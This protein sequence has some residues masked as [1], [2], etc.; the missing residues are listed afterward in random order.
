MVC[1][2]NTDEVDAVKPTRKEADADLACSWWPDLKDIWT[3]LRWPECCFG[4][5][6]WHDGAV[7]SE[8]AGSKW[9]DDEGGQAGQYTF[10]FCPLG[11]KV[12]TPPTVR[13]SGAARQG[14]T[15]SYAP[16]LWTEWNLGHLYGVVVRAYTFAH[17]PG[18]GLP[19]T[20]REAPFAWVRFCIHYV[21]PVVP[22]EPQ[23]AFT[24]KVDAPHITTVPGYAYDAAAARYPRPL[25]SHHAGGRLSHGAELLEEDDRIRMALLPSECAVAEWMPQADDKAWPED[26]RYWHVQMDTARGHCLDMLLTLHPVPADDFRREAALGYSGALKEAET[27]WGGHLGASRTRVTT[28][29]T[30]IDDVVRHGLR[31]ALM[32]TWKR[33]GTG[34]AVMN[35]AAL[36]YDAHWPTQTVQTMI[37]VLDML[38]HHDLAD[39]YMEVFRRHQGTATPTMTGMGRHPGYLAAPVMPP[40]SWGIGGKGSWFLGHG[41]I[42]WAAAK[43]ALLTMDKDFIDRWTE[44]VVKA[45]EFTRDARACRDHEGVK[46]IMPPG[47]GTDWEGAGECAPFQRT[48]NDGWMYKGLATAARFLASIGHP[49]AGEFGSEARDYRQTFQRELRARAATYPSWQASDGKT[50]HMVPPGM[51]KHGDYELRWEI[52]LDCGPLF[53]V[54]AELLDAEDP[55]MEGTRRWF[56]EGPPVSAY[57]ITEDSY[58]HMPALIHEMGTGE[59][60]FSWNAFHSLELGDRRHYLEAM[61]SL[62]AGS[63]SR[64]TFGACEERGGMRGLNLTLQ[65]YTVRLAVIEERGE[66]LHLCRMLPLAWLHAGDTTAFEDMPT[67]FGP[68]TLRL[69]LADQGQRLEVLFEP[70]FRRPPARVVL[71]VPPLDTLTKVTVNGNSVDWESSSRRVLL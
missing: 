52:Y 30:L 11:K 35:L 56:R 50:Y 57:P 7:L 27:F 54:F 69:T 40:G 29:E 51:S 62:A 17:L 59:C 66:E 12:H 8:L 34:E 23:L 10:G 18:A 15:D 6:V 37:M 60:E 25:H 67:E 21:Y 53:L 55:L 44:P 39:R 70:R 42:Q 41:A 13:D 58:H 5:T 43:H 9:P 49:R 19:E 64:Q 68:V 61:Y 16:V 24:L 3:P 20:G 14:W 2:V 71:H 31:N 4:Y 26:G 22:V 65:V 47:I 36:R 28:H 46:G 63:V 45:C 1:L 33:P 48:W 38:G 32:T